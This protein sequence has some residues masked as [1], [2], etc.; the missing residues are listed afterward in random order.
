MPFT[1]AYALTVRRSREC[2]RLSPTIDQRGD[3][4]TLGSGAVAELT[5]RKHRVQFS[6]LHLHLPLCICGSVCV[7]GS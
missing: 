6:C 4:V 7:R 2:S 5:Y 3:P 1:T